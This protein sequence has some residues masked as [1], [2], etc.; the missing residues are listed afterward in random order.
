MAMTYSIG[1]SVQGRHLVVTR[2]SK[3]VEFSKEKRQRRRI[4]KPL[5]K[6]VANMHGNEVRKSPI[7]SILFGF[8]SERNLFLGSLFFSL[9]S[10]LLGEN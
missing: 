5:V 10:R 3:E 7:F 8:F 2:I 6:L 4:L 9:F 1:Q